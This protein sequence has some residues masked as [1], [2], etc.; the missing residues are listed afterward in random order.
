MNDYNFGNFVCH[1]REKQGMTQAELAQRLGV[2]PA[3]I[4]KWENGSSKP[5]V[6]ALFQLAEI[7][8]VRAEELMAGRY[9]EEPLDP[10]SV[11]LI[12]ERYEHLQR[13]ELHN[14]SK[15]KISRAIAWIIDWNIIGLAV[16]LA[17]SLITPFITPLLNSSDNV[18]SAAS[19]LLF[20]LVALSFPVCFIL[21]DIIFGGRSLGKR[22]LGLTI[23]DIKTGS[24][25][26]KTS[27]LLRNI[28]LFIVHIDFAVMLITGLT[29][30]DR[31]AHTVVI[32]KKDLEFLTDPA[33]T[34]PNTDTLNQYASD[35]ALHH[36]ANKKRNVIWGCIIAG[37]VI[38][39][40]VVVY[41]FVQIQLHI[42]KETEEYQ[43][44]Y[45]YVVESNYF[46]ALG[47]EE[48]MLTFT[49]YSLHTYTN[50]NGV[51]QQDAT[52]GFRIRPGKEI[53]VFLHNVGN[54]WYVCRDCTAFE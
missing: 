6:E 37:A 8:G 31:A 53:S 26:K 2:T 12:N 38:L 30:G 22:I 4:S 46:D 5:R 35:Q 20:L 9:L 34:E 44:A 39:F 19:V 21:R 7:L 23:T 47:V 14:T 40:F 3:A 17:L 50:K 52:I 32:R 36:Q 49:S 13:I 33:R 10:E 27:L 43:L 45:S 28:F 54:G 41:I 18:S 1:L 51:K 11:K 25:P 15:T 42:S 29:I 24:A 16:I 48:D